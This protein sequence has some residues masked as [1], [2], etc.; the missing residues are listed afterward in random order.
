MV[1][2]SAV[3]NAFALPG[4]RVYVLSALLGVAETPDELAGVLSHEFGHVAHRDSLR[5]LVR[6]GGTAFLI[7]LMFGDVTGAGTVLMAG[8]A[9]LSA[10]YSRADEELADA[11]AVSVMRRLG[12]PTAPLGAL[13]QRISGPTQNEA[14]SI[15]HDHPLTHD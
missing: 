6:D 14:S 3:A 2:R 10:S 8:R 12:R 4:G 9:V 15:L 7:G 11:F 1:L 5:R 13:L